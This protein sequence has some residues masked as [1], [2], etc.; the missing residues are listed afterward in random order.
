[1]RAL[2]FDADPKR[3][4]LIKALSTVWK[5]AALSRLSPLKYAEV[6]EPEIPGPNWVKVKNKMCGLCGSDVHFLFMEI[7]PR[8]APAAVPALPRKFLGHEMVGAVVDAGE[9]AAE[10]RRGDRVIQRIDWPSC[11]QKESAPMC[12]QCARGN[13][14]LCENPGWEGL[15]LNVGGGFSPY[16][17]LHKT[18]L[19]KIDDAMPDEHAILIEPTAC[20]V[21]AVL[22]RP[23]GEGE[24]ALVIGTGA[25][26]LSLIGVARAMHPDVEIHATYRY[27]HQAEMAMALGASGVVEEKDAYRRVAEITGGRHFSGL[28]N[29]EMVIGGFDVIYDTVGSDRSLKDALRWA[30]SEGSV[31]VVGINFAPKKLDYSPVWFQ[32]VKLF[33]INCHGREVFRGEETNSFEVALTLYREEAL[34]F[35]N[36]V[37]HRFPV[38]DYLKAIETF[39]DKGK[40]RVVKIALVHA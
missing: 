12:R 21:R 15:P 8:V 30:R 1:M 11:F 27:P 33:G 24:K 14:P 31:V 7:D 10:F 36:F 9:G 34:D 35:S 6:E 23:P 2:Y 17:V 32:E 20:A 39:L 16:M 22:K 4:A 3:I 40:T 26:G 37:T 19:I 38:Q 29:N 25:I 5:K 13:Y 28:F 18:Q